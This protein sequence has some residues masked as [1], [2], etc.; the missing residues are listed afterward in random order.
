MTQ[1]FKKKH[2]CKSAFLVSY[3]FV[4]VLYYSPLLL[5]QL[6][7]ILVAGGVVEGGVYLWC[8][9]LVGVEWCAL[10]EGEY[11]LKLVDGGL[12]DVVND[13]LVGD[14]GGYAIYSR[15][16]HLLRCVHILYGCEIYLHNEFHDVVA[17]E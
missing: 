8:F 4:E 9:F 2:F 17:Q 11:V 10:N 13:V 15:Y 6:V 16:E 1:I 5:L 7:E 3:T 14:V 12:K